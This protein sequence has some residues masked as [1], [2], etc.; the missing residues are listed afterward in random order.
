MCTYTSI[1]THTMIIIQC[2][3]ILSLSTCVEIW[4]SPP[5]TRNFAFPVYVHVHTFVHV[6]NE[7]ER[8]RERE[9]ENKRERTTERKQGKTRLKKR[10][11]RQNTTGSD[12]VC[13]WERE[14]ER[15]RERKGEKRERVCVISKLCQEVP[16]EYS[17]FYRAFLQKRPIILNHINLCVQNTQIDLNKW[18]L[19][20]TLSLPQTSRANPV[21]CCSTH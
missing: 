18:K 7:R 20:W 9:R 11:T 1:N 19:G 14:R 4:G 5:N 13:V 3:M 6:H 21:Q 8:E 10:Q 16:A 2:M 12:S 17:L 15:E